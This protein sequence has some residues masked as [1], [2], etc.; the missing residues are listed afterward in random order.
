MRIITP[1]ALL[2]FSSL[3]HAGNCVIDLKADDQMKFDQANVTV[4][5]S[6]PSIEIRLTHTGKLP[7]AS[8]GHNVAI[9][10][11]DVYLAVAQEG[12]KAGAA[13]DYLPLGDK[14]VIAHTGLIGGGASI[15][16]SFAGSALTPG[17]DYTFYCSFPG[18]WAIMKGKLVVE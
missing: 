16:A 10:P 17:G 14:R 6:C 5:A 3:S 11:T 2:L 15:T 9:S 1:F 18:H 4:S 13:S 12:M 8:M 7:V